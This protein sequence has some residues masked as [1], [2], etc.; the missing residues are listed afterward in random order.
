MSLTLPAIALALAV[1]VG[2]MAGSD[3]PPPTWEAPQTD[4]ATAASNITGPP[5]IPF[6]P[7]VGPRRD[8]RGVFLDG[9][10]LSEV[11]VMSLQSTNASTTWG[12]Y[13]EV[14]PGLAL[15]VGS[16]SF[17]LS[18]GY[19]PR[20]TA[21]FDVGRLQ[22]AVLNRAT[23]RASWDIDPLW[24]LD[25]RGLFVVGDYSQLMPASTP[26]GAGPTPPVLNPVR[27]FLTY[28]YVG[29]DTMLGLGATLSPRTRLRVSGGYFDVGGTGEWGQAN[30]PRTWGPQAEAA[31]DW[32]ATRTG[33][34][35]ASVTAQDWMMSGDWNVLLAVVTAAWRQR[36]SSEF[37]TVISAGPAMSNRDIESS[38]SFRHLT[39]AASLRL[40]YHP[41]TRQA[42]RLSLDA[43]LTPYVDA[44]LQVPYQ[45]LTA[46][47]SLDWHPSDAW[48]VGASLAAALL[49][50]S[51]L[52]ATSFGNAGAS[53]SWAPVRF[54][55]LTAGGFVQS[56]L[57]GASPQASGFVQWTGYVSLTL[58]DRLSL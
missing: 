50:Y 36:W 45:R 1:L 16:P 47:A 52:E 23:V 30:Q 48:Q 34:F 15:E 10:V 11:R 27:S 19:A 46:T 49:P 53:A 9:A 24:T 55:V 39:P 51:V 5:G 54:L 28:P 42:L 38:T 41:E 18:L 40:D 32:A 33:T 43:T 14:T 8:R 2:Q 37:D 22:L 12:S 3:G 35:T 31:I 21:P 4:G 17:A 44:Y 57:G 7:D 25:A 26:G 13:M 58:R 56:Q 6:M 29:I 20:L